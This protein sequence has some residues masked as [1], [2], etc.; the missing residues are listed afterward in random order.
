MKLKS[1][2]IAMLTALYGVAAGVAAADYQQA[3]QAA[4]LQQMQIPSAEFLAEMAEANKQRKLAVLQN[5]GKN[6]QLAPKSPEAKFQPEAEFSAGEHSYIVELHDESVIKQLDEAQQLQK[7]EQMVSAAASPAA[8]LSN[9]N[10]FKGAAMQAPVAAAKIAQLQQQQDLVLNTASAVLGRTLETGQRYTKVLNGFSLKMT[11][12]EAK[13]VAELAEVKKVTRVKMYQLTTDIGPTIIG[14]NKAWAGQTS[15]TQALKGEGMVVGIIDTGINTDHAS[16]APTGADGY[17]VTNPLGAGNYLGDCKLKD[18]ASRCNDK[19]IGVYSY[20]KITDAYS[21]DEFQD[22]N[23]PWYAPNVQI[24]PKFGEDYNG[25]GSHTASTAAGNVLTNVPHLGSSGKQGDGVPTGF[26]FGQI[27]GVAPHANIVSFQVCFPGA[28]GDPYAGCPG[29]VLVAAIE[30]AVDAGVDVINFSIGG[31]EDSPWESPME[32]AF[33]AA[34]AAGVAVAASAGNSGAAGSNEQMS[35]IDHS[36]PWLMNVA[37][38]TT[39]RTIDVVNKTLTGFSGGLTTPPTITGKSISGAVT[40]SLK[41]AQK[42]G[43]KLCLNPFPAGT[44]TKDDIVICERGTNARTAKADNVKAGGAGGFILYNVSS[45]ATSPEGMTF[46]DMYSIPGIHISANDYYGKL[47]NWLNKGT[48][49]RATITAAN[50]VRNMNPANADILANFSS[51]GPSK[52]IK[53]H[54]IPM[55]SAPGA[56]IFAAN[57]DDQPFSASQ[58]ASDFTMMS[59]TSMAS[60]HVAGALTLLRQAHPDWSVSEAQS[61]LQ[62]T[63]KQVVKYQKSNTLVDAGIYRAGSG[64]IDVNAAIDA[65]LVLHETVENFKAADPANGG[66]VRQLNMP[67]LV[68]MQCKESC[69]WVRTFRATRDGDWKVQPDTDEYSFSIEATPARFSLKKGEVQT[70]VFTAKLMNSNSHSHSAEGELHAAVKLIADQPNIPQVHLPVAVKYT[71][72]GVPEN[73]QMTMHRNEGVYQIN[74]LNLPPLVSGHYSTSGYVKPDIKELAIEQEPDLCGFACDRKLGPSKHVSLVQVPA[75]SAR[76]MVEVLSRTHSTAKKTEPWKRGD[77]DVFVGYDVNNDGIPQWNEEAVCM[78][79]SEEV[80]DYCNITNPHP[81][82]YWVVVNNYQHDSIRN[83]V[84]VDTYKVA[85]AVVPK[86]SNGDIE[87]EGPAQHDAIAPASIKLR[88]DMP[89]AEVGDLY[90]TMLNIGTSSDQPANIAQIPLKMQRGRDEIELKGSK[91]G[92]RP[93]QVIDMSFNVMANQDGYD[94]DIQ[95]TSKLPSHM[96]LVPGSVK[97]PADMQKGLKVD[98]NNFVLTTVQPD[99][100]DWAR[101]YKVTTNKTDAMCKIPNYGQADRN[102]YLDLSQYGINPQYGG[103]WNEN[104]VVQLGW[105]FGEDATAA[106]YHNYYAGSTKQFTISPMGY[107]Q[108]D[109]MPLY[110]PEHRRMTIQNFPDSMVA[111]LWRGATLRPDYK[112]DYAPL[113]TP[114]FIDRYN[115][116]NSSGISMAIAGTGDVI[117]EWDNARSSE[118]LYDFATNTRKWVDRPDKYDFEVIYSMNYRHAAGQYEIIMAYDNLTFEDNYGLGS[119]GIH[120]FDTYRGAFGPVGGWKG[121]DIGMNDLKGKLSNDLIICYDY[122]GPEV[123]TFD[124]SFQVMVNGDA[125]GKAQT[126]GLEVARSGLPTQL[127]THD[128]TVNGNLKVGALNNLTMAEDAAAM[129]VMVGYSDDNT[130][131]NTISVTGDGIETVVKGHEPGAVFSL[132]PKANFNGKTKVTVTVTD[133]L[134][135]TDSASTSFDLTVT[136]VQDAPVAKVAAAT[137]NVTAGSAITLDASASTDVDGDTLSYSWAGPGTISNGNTAKASVSGLTAGSHNFTVTVSDGLASS[138]AQVTVTVSDAPAVVVTPP[139][140]SSGGSIGWFT[141]LLLPLLRLRKTAVKS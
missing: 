67:E 57:S 140:K 121:I 122:T 72:G 22:K 135:P 54:L 80:G 107:L 32:Q 136:P 117:L 14:A 138:T 141:L 7:A 128:V 120:G 108:L 40:G 77:A 17:T 12:D 126:V 64:R 92:A 98:A 102:S 123:T 42:F 127:L 41:V 109:Q 76:L 37:A 45:S 93:G 68:N 69:T 86:A 83:P 10:N 119:V 18:F 78:S 2:T 43:D 13:R 110:F 51:R 133:S 50:V 46:N 106:L 115:P 90:Y 87:V 48:D 124:V 94:R 75:D 1:I 70:V 16:F 33:L 91:T 137:L 81:G 62:M 125:A 5:N 3:A 59:G 118:E 63:A 8:N 71:A 101:D 66:A 55:V 27:S 23:K 112:T 113:R 96:T 95:L 30:D 44:F 114:L 104:L 105:Y 100:R 82:Q 88:W 131:K 11:Q 49:H 97:V 53:E 56:D 21:A 6:V 52:Y 31:P 89:D 73:M 61:A 34:H 103:I 139:A 130:V 65:G 26:T 36:S 38:T 58:N 60:P 134:V 29:D 74:D 85:T 116:D 35:V 4:E 39:G 99:S 47:S 19:L 79:A 28:A 24:R 84:I 20:S 132:K 25:H 129:D 111:P 15:V 9:A